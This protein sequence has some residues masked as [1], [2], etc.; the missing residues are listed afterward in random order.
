MKIYR[1]IT[2][3]AKAWVVAKSF[4]NAIQVWCRHTKL[5]LNDLDEDTIINRTGRKTARQI[6]LGEFTLHDMVRGLDRPGVIHVEN[7]PGIAEIF[8]A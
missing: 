6:R 8:H 1:I 7:R 5:E 4:V 2:P 3:T